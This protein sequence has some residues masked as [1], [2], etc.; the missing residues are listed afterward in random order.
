M[1]WVILVLITYFFSW[2]NKK[3]PKKYFS[4]ASQGPNLGEI[5]QTITTRYFSVK[6]CSKLWRQ[7]K[8]LFYSSICIINQTRIHLDYNSVRK[9]NFLTW[10][11][12]DPMVLNEE[13]SYIPHLCVFCSLYQSNCQEN[14]WKICVFSLAILNLDYMIFLGHMWPNGPL[15]QCTISIFCVCVLRSS[16]R[17]FQVGEGYTRFY[18][19]M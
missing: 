1:K 10:V 8:Q 19:Q 6:P 4:A 3:S 7:K 15:W 5:P 12:Y 2:N 9:G 11:I 16:T 17:P 18:R 14:L 13:N